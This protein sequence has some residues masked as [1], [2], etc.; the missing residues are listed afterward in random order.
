MIYKINELKDG[1]S[2]VEVEFKVLE[3]IDQ[4]SIISKTGKGKHTV[5][6]FRVADDTGSIILSAWNKRVDDFEVDENYR[7]RN[8]KI[9]SFKNKLQINVGQFTPIEQIER[10][11]ELG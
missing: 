5:A 3:F 11:I 8:C 1:F 2:G 4:R 10:S 6:S 7:I 9:S